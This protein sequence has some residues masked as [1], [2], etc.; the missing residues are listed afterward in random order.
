MQLVKA[1]KKLD[2][3]VKEIQV[4]KAGA[5]RDFLRI[6]QLLSQV[7]DGNLWEMTDA[8]TFAEWAD[9]EVGF[10]KTTSYAAIGVYETWASTIGANKELLA[11][12]HS[13]LVRL[14]PITNNAE[15]AEEN[16]HN[17]LV[18]SGSDFDEYLRSKKGQR[19]QTECMHEGTMEGP[20]WKCP[21]CD[22]FLKGANGESGAQGSPT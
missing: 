13:R 1:D 12:D 21:A 15:Q 18:L 4:C 3:I 20:F 9:R 6:G 8:K 22:K 17:A 14:L 7:R 2:E 10:K 16:A 11:V 19:L 5:L